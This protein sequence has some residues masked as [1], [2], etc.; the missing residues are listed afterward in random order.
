M[1][2]AK[3]EKTEFV[4]FANVERVRDI[5]VKIRAEGFVPYGEIVEQFGE[6][7]ATQAIAILYRNLRVIREVTRPFGKEQNVKGYEW[8]DIR[9][10]KSQLAKLPPQYEW[11]AELGSGGMAKYENFENIK[12]LCR[13][14]NEILGSLPTKDTDGEFNGFLRT[15]GHVSIVR[16]QQ[17]AM[18]AKTLPMIGKDAA[19]ARRIGWT[20]IALKPNKIDFLL[21]P[22]VDEAKR[23]GLGITR[24]ERI[25]SGCEFTI[26]AMVPTS[27]LSIAD[28]IRGLREAGKRIGLSPARS[29]GFGDF[30]VVKVITE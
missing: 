2:K 6:K 23:Q 25:H 7:D 4:P 15:N 9:F 29:A 16:Y 24:H 5:A 26:D 17:R 3:K 8:G 12:V 21:L 14:T 11:I 30:E 27:H 1:K 13:W 18:F 10:T 28:F 22:K 19:I 20:M